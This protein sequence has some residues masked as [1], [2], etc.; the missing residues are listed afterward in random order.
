MT[1][2]LGPSQKQKGLEQ[3]GAPAGLQARRSTVHRRNVSA[4]AATYVVAEWPFISAL[5]ICAHVFKKLCVFVCS[6][7]RERDQLIKEHQYHMQV[8][9]D[10]FQKEMDLMDIVKRDPNVSACGI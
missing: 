5:R 6:H 10:C 8:M 1:L 2:G 3:S 4:A 9:G 7:N